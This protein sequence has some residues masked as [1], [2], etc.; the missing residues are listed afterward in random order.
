MVDWKS[1]NTVPDSVELQLSAYRKGLEEM[2]DYNE[3]G[4]P[5]LEAPKTGEKIELPHSHQRR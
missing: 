3:D 4:N 5:Y 1:G 2:V